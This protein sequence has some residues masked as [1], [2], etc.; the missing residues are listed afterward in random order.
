MSETTSREQVKKKYRVHRNGGPDILFAEYVQKK[1]LHHK[2]ACDY[3]PH[4][5]AGEQSGVWFVP[6]RGQ[7]HFKADFRR[8]LEM[9]VAVVNADKRVHGYVGGGTST[10]IYVGLAVD[11]FVDHRGELR[12]AKLSER[13]SV[14]KET[15][16]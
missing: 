16:F 9:T 14:R 4:E 13:A 5:W 15:D 6:P 11:H 2:I 10:E 12:I 8:L 7:T 3:L 1:L